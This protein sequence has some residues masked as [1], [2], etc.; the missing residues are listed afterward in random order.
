[1]FS[2]SLIKSIIFIMIL[3]FAMSKTIIKPKLCN[4]YIFIYVQTY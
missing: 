2:L 3:N 4:I 1:M